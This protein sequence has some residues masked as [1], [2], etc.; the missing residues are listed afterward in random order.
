MRSAFDENP[1]TRC[2]ADRGAHRGRRCQ[3][4]RAW[5]RDQQHRQRL[6]RTVREEQHDAGERERAGDE[7]RGEVLA[8]ELNFRFQL[9]RFFDAA[10]EATDRGVGA[11]ARDANANMSGH[12]QRAGPNASARVTLNGHALA[13]DRRFVDR[14]LAAFDDAV[15]CNL[16]SAVDRDE[17]ADL[18]RARFAFRFEFAFD[19]PDVD[20]IDREEIANRAARPLDREHFEIRADAQEE[21]DRERAECFSE[22][23]ARDRRGCDERV[24]RDLFL[25]Y[26]FVCAFEIRPTACDGG[27]AGDQNE[28]R[29]AAAEGE[30]ENAAAQRGTADARFADVLFQHLIRRRVDGAPELHPLLV[31]FF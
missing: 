1:A 16:F 28:G 22:D 14:R 10:N 17:I 4:R 20:I 25:A 27:G 21:D 31:L 11:D 2:V 12:H 29:S 5:T 15:D 13:G 30:N 26:R 3:S 9:V 24:G 8:R 7:M 23:D 6:R 19:I 18:D